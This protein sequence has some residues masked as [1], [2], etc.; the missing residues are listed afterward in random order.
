MQTE[1]ELSNYTT[2]ILDD[3]PGRITNINITCSTL[4]NTIVKNGETFSFNQ[5]VGE[6]TA[7][8]GYQ[9]AK[10]IV[11]D[12]AELGIG[13][14]NCQVSS[15][16]YDAVMAVPGLVVTERHEHGKD[17]G[18]VPLG[19]DATIAYGSLDLQFRNDSGR[20]IRIDAIT[21]NS[22]VNITIIGL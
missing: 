16:L 17:V 22:S 8:K 21:D 2:E 1:I 7:E 12:E 14:G 4:N 15:T 9:D 20:D 18:Y 3:T 10:I 5:T 19:M 13:G 11:D 6:P